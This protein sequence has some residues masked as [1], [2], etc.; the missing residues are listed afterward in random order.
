LFGGE[1]HKKWSLFFGAPQDIVGKSKT[2]HEKPEKLLR[3]SFFLHIYLSQCT[4]ELFPSHPF[5]ITP[6]RH[7]VI[8]LTAECTIPF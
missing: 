8:H 3:F 7:T 2:E 4:G 6:L 1:K 5:R